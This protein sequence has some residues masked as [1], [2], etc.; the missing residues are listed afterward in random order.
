MKKTLLVAVTALF[1]TACFAS[2][3]SSPLT[4][5]AT[6]AVQGEN[7]D[8]LLDEYEQFVNKYISTMKKA[9]NGDMS[10]YADL[11]TIAAKAEK[12]QAKLEK[13]EDDMTTAQAARYAKITEK[14]TKALM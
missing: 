11:A 7:W 10:A 8:K 1:G 9:Q 2:T 6:V 5:C 13:A 3:S 4:V 12:L 14:M